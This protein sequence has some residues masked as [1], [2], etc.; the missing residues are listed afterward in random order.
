MLLQESVILTI[1]GIRFSSEDV[2]VDVDLRYPS[3][4]T[5]ASTVY[6]QTEGFENAKDLL[7]SIALAAH[8]NIEKKNR[9][10]R[11]TF[12]ASPPGDTRIFWTDDIRPL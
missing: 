6:L 11:Q 10:L 7:R 5:V 8:Q 9:E 2:A 12:D 1:K 3:N 4:Y